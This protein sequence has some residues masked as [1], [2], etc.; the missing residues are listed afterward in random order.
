[1][2]VK[3]VLAANVALF[4]RG[5]VQLAGRV[6]VF[7]RDGLEGDIEFDRRVTSGVKRRSRGTEE[8]DDATTTLEH[9]TDVPSNFWNKEVEDMSLGNSSSLTHR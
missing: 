1:M 8:S 3:H 7:V 2:E 6:L 9:I 4:L 5:V